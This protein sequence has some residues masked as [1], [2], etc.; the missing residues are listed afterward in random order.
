MVGLGVRIVWVLLIPPWAS[1]DE[2]AHFT[3]VTHLVEQ[4]EIPTPASLEGPLP[5]YAEEVSKSWE[6]VAITQISGLGSKFGGDRG[7]LAVNHDYNKA[8]RY[9]APRAQRM[10]S[11]GA[12]ASSYPPVY[13][14]FSAIFYGIFDEAPLLARLYAARASSAVLGAFT[15]CFTYLLAWELARSR[16]WAQ[17]AALAMALMP[18][19]AF[20]TASVNNDAA[21]VLVSTAICWL[22]LVCLRKPEITRGVAVGLG[23]LCGLILV[24]KQTAALLIPITAVLLAVRAFPISL[25]PWRI[26]RERVI[27]LAMFGLALLAIDAPWMIFRVLTAKVANAQATVEIGLM[28]TML[29]GSKYTL[30]T[31]IQHQVNQGSDYFHWLLIRTFWG[32]FGWLEVFLPDS[33][34]TAIAGLYVIASVGLVVRFV[35]DRASRASTLLLLGVVLG[36]LLFIFLIVDY[37]WYFARVGSGLGLQGRYFFVALGPLLALLV[38][39]CSALFRDHPV[40]V[41]LLPLASLLLALQSFSTMLTYYYSV[42]F[43]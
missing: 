43:S 17:A 37:R 16:A 35:R 12:S 42:V 4:G 24:T 22:L 10:T 1:P 25:R 31:Y 27:V 29:D 30:A 36:H 3:Y 41:R 39:G 26:L 19:H 33:A 9:N 7:Y 20:I 6:D 14:A 2:P 23:V 11:A 34:Y 38:S 21:M 32:T 15:C 13:Y 18:M 28:S 40:A 5:M 8:R